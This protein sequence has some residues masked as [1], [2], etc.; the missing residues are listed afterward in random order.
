MEDFQ[1]PRQPSGA[2]LLEEMSSVLVDQYVGH[3]SEHGFE[4]LPVQR[5]GTL[6]FRHP[7]LEEVLFLAE[8]DRFAHPGERIR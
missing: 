1:S 2:F 3:P 7:G 5:R 8:I 4:L 6:V